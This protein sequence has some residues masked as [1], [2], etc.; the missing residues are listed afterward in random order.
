MSAGLT[1]HTL[2]LVNGQDGGGCVWWVGKFGGNEIRLVTGV[3]GRD[4][5]DRRDGKD[6]GCVKAVR[7]VRDVQDAGCGG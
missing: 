4:V 6:A 1:E 3:D 2:S 7:C 5:E